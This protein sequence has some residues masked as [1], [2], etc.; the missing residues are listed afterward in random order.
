MTTIPQVARAMREI[1]T[2]TADEAARTTRF[3]QRTSPLSGA[4]FSQTLVFGFLGNPQATLEELT[5]TAATLGVAISPQALDQRFTASAAACLQQVLLTAIAQVITAEPVTIPLLQRFTAVY[6]QDSSTIVLP[7]VFAAQ[8]HGC[9]GSTASGASAALKLQARLEMGTGR[10]DVQLQEG[11]ASDRAAVLPGPLPAGALRLADLGYWSLE[12]F[13]A[14][15]QHEVFWLSRLQMQTAVY[16]A[17][18]DRRDL[19]ELLEA[20]PTDT[21]ELA[22]TLGERQRLAARLLAVRVPQDV[23]ATRRRRL[24]QTAR[25]KGRQ[26]SATRLALAAWTIFVTNVPTERLTLR[27][28]LVL[29]RMRW[30]IELLFKL[31]KSQGRVDES[32]STKPWRILCEV[33]AKLLAMLVQH[34]VFLASLWAYPDRSLTK[35]AQTVQ[36]HA[37]HLASVF[38]SVKRL[39]AALLTVKR[40]LAVGCR[41]NRRK[42]HPNTYQLLLD[43]SGSWREP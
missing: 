17:T 39:A 38:A 12:A 29:G 40:C 2:T 33:Y 35:A 14:L 23:A 25:D 42:K 15:A 7:E 5:Q 10:L 26:V 3:V 27:E 1:L 9:G 31:W 24:R 6:V 28:T 37:L 43:A 41:M 32:R 22:V 21:I 4:T 11:R 8:W 30:Q 18:G 16:D 13:A 20:Q 34:W 36:K 19:L